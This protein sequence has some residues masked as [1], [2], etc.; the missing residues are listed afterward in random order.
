V[1]PISQRNLEEHLAG[2]LH[3]S[4]VEALQARNDPAEL[5][6]KAA[7]GQWNKNLI[8]DGESLRGDDEENVTENTGS[9]RQLSVKDRL[10]PARSRWICS[11]CQAKCTSESNYNEHLR[12]RRHRE[13]TEALCAESRSDS[14]SSDGD[15]GRSADWKRSYYCDVCD[16]QCNSEKMLASH[17]G[18]RR[19]REALE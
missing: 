17:L 7:P 1:S 10:E 18:G 19:H 5:N 8:K 15:A 14:E 3:Q 11:I 6:T 13:N 4:N 12:G 2:R 16:L 9:W